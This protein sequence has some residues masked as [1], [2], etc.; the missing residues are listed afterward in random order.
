MLPSPSSRSLRFRLQES[1]DLGQWSDLNLEQ[2]IIGTPRNMGD[3]TE[4]VEVLGTL[5]FSGPA[6]APKGFLRVAVEKP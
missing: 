5:P 3:G 4:F 6:T 2:R 1:P